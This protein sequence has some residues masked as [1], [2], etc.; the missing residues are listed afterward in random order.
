MRRRLDEL[1]TDCYIVDVTMKLSRFRC[2][3]AVTK[4]FGGVFIRWFFRALWGGAPLVQP[5]SLQA[6]ITS[7]SKVFTS[8]DWG[9]FETR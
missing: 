9:F 8:E 2:S 7:T 4:S 6:D 3:R 5:L 1:V